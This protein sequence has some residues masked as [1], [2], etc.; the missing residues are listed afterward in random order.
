MPSLVQDRVHRPIHPDDHQQQ[1]GEEQGVSHP[2]EDE[3]MGSAVD[4]RK[5]TDAEDE[6][7]QQPHQTH[8]TS[9]YGIGHNARILW[10]S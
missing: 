6:T 2:P 3:Q 8:A 9:Q 10:N 7:A 5:S 1:P 4:H